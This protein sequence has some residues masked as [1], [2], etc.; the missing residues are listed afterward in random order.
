MGNGPLI[1]GMSEFDAPRKRLPVWVWWVASGIALVLV[2]IVLGGFFGGVGPLRSVGLV[3]Q[4]LQPVSYRPTTND[5]VIQV[6][7]AL[8]AS[9]LC[10]D[11]EISVQAFERGPRVELEATAIS[12][13]TSSCPSTGIAGDRAW[14]DVQLRENLGERTV[15]RTVDRQALPRDS[16]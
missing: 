4:T 3:Q 1:P 6:A 12:P 8:P 2:L 10:P 16:S 5:S 15:I 13:R 11:T 14:V 7:V 9:S